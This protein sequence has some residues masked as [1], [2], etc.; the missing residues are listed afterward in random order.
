MGYKVFSNVDERCDAL[1][2]RIPEKCGNVARAA[3]FFLIK[4]IFFYSLPYGL[5]LTNDPEMDEIILQS[6]FA[7][8]LRHSWPD[9]F[10]A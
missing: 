2:D 1:I 9:I 4:V 10:Y 3:K 8:T 6:S 7:T 5:F